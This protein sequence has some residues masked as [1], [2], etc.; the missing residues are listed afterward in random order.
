MAETVITPTRLHAGPAR[1][2]S[3]KLRGHDGPPVGAACLFGTPSA[4]LR[5]ACD[6][7][8]SVPWATKQEDFR[9][10]IGEPNGGAPRNLG[11]W[12]LPQNHT[13]VRELDPRI[14]Q[15]AA[16]MRRPAGPWMDSVID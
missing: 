1:I 13:G 8:G 10:W 5:I 4:R 6:L 7:K 12:A 14:V 16:V 3:S 2:R 9:A 11:H 15:T